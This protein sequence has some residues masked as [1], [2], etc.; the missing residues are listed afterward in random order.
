MKKVEQQPAGMEDVR[1]SIGHTSKA[2][3]LL[4]DVINTFDFPEGK[5]LLRY[6]RPGA[7]RIASLKEKLKSRGV[8]CIYV[9]DYFGLWQSDFRAQV[10]HCTRS[11][12]AGAEIATRLRPER[13]DYFVLKPKHSGFYA[14]SLDVLLRY[15]GAKHLILAGFAGNICVLYTANDA[16]MR[17]FTLTVPQDCVASETKSLNNAA[18]RHMRDFLGADIRPSTTRGFVHSCTRGPVK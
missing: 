13:D 7:E 17:D 11:E 3:L 8:P 15:L 5:K 6:A 9:N 4:I 18:C 2:V 14:T 10:D 1:H 16:Y 12:S